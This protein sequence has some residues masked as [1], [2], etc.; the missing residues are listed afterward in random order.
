MAAPTVLVSPF[1]PRSRVRGPPSTS[2]A[3]IARSI[4]DVFPSQP[5]MESMSATLSAE[6]DRW[7][8]SA[9]STDDRAT[10]LSADPA[11]K[12][13]DHHEFDAALDVPFTGAESTGARVLRRIEL[14]LPA[15]G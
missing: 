4:A 11:A 7:S 12:Y 9:A 1:P 10:A 3:A 2:D 5:G 14:R 13:P 15:R 8:S 6:T